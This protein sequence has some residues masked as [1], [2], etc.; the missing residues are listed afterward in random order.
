MS[1]SDDQH[2]PKPLLLFVEDHADSRTMYAEYL[3]DRFD[4]I[5]AENGVG[6]WDILQQRPVDVLVTDLGLP[7]LD[8]YELIRRIRADARLR[9]LPIVALSG[10]SGGQLESDTRWDLVLQKP[11]LPDQV[12]EAVAAVLS[13]RRNR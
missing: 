7:A 10:Y 6:A 13:S 1:S 8:G 2:G 11:C 9:D 5:E 12:V 3:S 4:V